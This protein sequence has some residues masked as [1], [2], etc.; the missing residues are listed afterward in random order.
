M[1]QAWARKSNGPGTARRYSAVFA[2][3]VTATATDASR[4]RTSRST[5]PARVACPYPCPET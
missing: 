5:S 1:S 2:G 4:A 3:E